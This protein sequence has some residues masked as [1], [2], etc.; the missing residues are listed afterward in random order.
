MPVLL[1]CKRLL[2]I[3]D[4]GALSVT[5]PLSPTPGGSTCDFLT[6]LLHDCCSVLFIE[7][8]NSDPKTVPVIYV[9]ASAK[10]PVSPLD[11][12]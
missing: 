12:V 10:F 11:F 8:T 9:M 4:S 1:D 5:D 7:G 6:S 3:T 2:Q